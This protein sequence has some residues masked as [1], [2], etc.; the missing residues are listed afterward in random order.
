MNAKAGLPSE[1]TIVLHDVTYSIN[2]KAL[3]PIINC[4]SLEIHVVK[5][6]YFWAAAAA[7][8]PPS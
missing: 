3:P 7:A 6:W 2:G 5:L 4:I 1:S 8:K